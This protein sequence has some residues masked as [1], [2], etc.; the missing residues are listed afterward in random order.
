MLH[1]R[2]HH[3]VIYDN[4]QQKPG[5]LPNRD[6]RLGLSLGL[7]AILVVGLLFLAGLASQ[8]EPRSSDGHEIVWHGG[9]PEEARAGSCWCSADKYCMCTPNLAIDLIIVSGKNRE[10][11]WLVRRKD[12]NQLAV[13]GGFVDVDETLEHAVKR[14]LK[15]EMDIELRKPPTLFGVYSDP[16]RDKRRRTVS[17]VYA[18]YLDEDAHPH[19]GDD[20]KEVKRI[21]LDEIEQHSYFA[22]HRSILLDYRRFVRGEPPKQSTEGDF[23]PDI[24]RSTCAQKQSLISTL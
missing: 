19:A 2:G 9:H 3:R 18:I 8:S 16:R 21:S 4:K 12:T 14:E 15:E 5:G 10:F 24:H 22:D 1:H 7:N 23:A 13:M 11:L 17:A 20:A 6:T